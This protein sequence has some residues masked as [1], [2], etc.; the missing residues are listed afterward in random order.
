MR[1]SGGLEG[2]SAPPAFQ[3]S[4]KKRMDAEQKL[5]EEQASAADYGKDKN[6]ILEEKEKRGRGRPKRQGVKLEVSLTKDDLLRVERDKGKR[7]PIDGDVHTADNVNPTESDV[8]KLQNTSSSS[9]KKVCGLTH[10]TSK[11]WKGHYSV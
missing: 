10:D 3:A 8:T 9:N 11:W 5:Q 2:G 6:K 4:E 1:V 7:S